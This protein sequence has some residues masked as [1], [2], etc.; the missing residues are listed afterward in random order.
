MEAPSIELGVY[1]KIPMANMYMAR[2]SVNVKRN[3]KFGESLH[4][5]A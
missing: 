1:R 2:V 4:L 5:I 3:N